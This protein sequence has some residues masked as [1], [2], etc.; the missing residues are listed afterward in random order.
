MQAAT[1]DDLLNPIISKYV[2]KVINLINLINCDVDYNYYIETTGDYTNEAKRITCYTCKIL[3]T[4]INNSVFDFMYIPANDSSVKEERIL[5]FKDNTMENSFRF[6][7]VGKLKDDWPLSTIISSDP[8][9][10]EL[11]ENQEKLLVYVLSEHD[12]LV[13]NLILKTLINPEPRLA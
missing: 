1:R 9:I 4:S 6:I 10:A 7:Y 11:N 2:N 5:Q 13:K 8:K 12:I 3:I